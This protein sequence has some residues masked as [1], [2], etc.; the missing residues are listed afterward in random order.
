MQTRLRDSADTTH[1]TASDMYDAYGWHLSTDERDIP[2][3]AVQYDWL[4]DADDVRVAG[5]LRAA[6]SDLTDDEAMDLVVMARGVREAMEGVSDL[7]DDAVDAYRRGDCEGCARA[8][9]HASAVE[10]DHGDDPATDA[11]REQLIV[12]EDA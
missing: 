11:L 6:D 2:L 1:E 3:Q 9:E 12:T 7:L 8:L 4:D 5:R 10:S